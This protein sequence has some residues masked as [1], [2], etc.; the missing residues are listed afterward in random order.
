LFQSGFSYR[1]VLRVLLRSYSDF[2]RL[3]F[4]VNSVSHMSQEV[5]QTQSE[6]EVRVPANGAGVEPPQAPHHIGGVRP[7]EAQ[8]S[9][10]GSA[11]AGGSGLYGR[12]R[13]RRE[14]RRPARSKD[15]LWT[16]HFFSLI[17]RE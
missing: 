12:A 3:A 16:A 13:P 2:E 15:A 6:G 5:R 7:N 4:H 9:D 8:P 17:R 11:N 14:P 1:A 10:G